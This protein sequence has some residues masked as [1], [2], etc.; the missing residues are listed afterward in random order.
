[1]LS[2]YSSSNTPNPFLSQ[3]ESTQQRILLVDDHTLFRAG[4]RLILGDDSDCLGAVLEASNLMDAMAVAHEID[5]V[6][7]DI[8]LPGLNGLDGLALIKKRWPNATAVILSAHEDRAS[9]TRAKQ[10]GAAAFVSKTAAPHEIRGVLKQLL[11]SRNGEASMR[12]F[13][14]STPLQRFPPEIDR[15]STESGN[16]LA[17]VL[18]ARQLE[19]LVLLGEGLSNKVIASHLNLAENTVRNHMVTI[20]R[21]FGVNTRTEAVVAAQRRGILK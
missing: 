13:S 15:L 18:S 6:V 17:Q 10:M 19:V 8:E 3:P 2:A 5:L 9:I 14:D 7:M 11:V 4:M 1:M 20:L 12:Y 21:Y 16:D